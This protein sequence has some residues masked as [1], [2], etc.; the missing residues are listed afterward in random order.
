MNAAMALIRLQNAAYMLVADN[1][2]FETMA[3]PVTELL[4][5]AITPALSVFGSVGA[6]YC[7][8]LGAKLAKAEEPQDR[9]KAKAALK[10]AIIGFVVIFLLLGALKVG[11]SAMDTWYQNVKTS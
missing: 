9:E 7:I 8:I 5:K 6:I 11:V 3:K 2:P 4:G 1:N 10:N